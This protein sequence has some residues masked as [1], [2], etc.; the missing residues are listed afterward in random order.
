MGVRKKLGWGV[1]KGDKLGEGKRRIEEK[2]K[3][4][5]SSEKKKKTVKPLCHL[6]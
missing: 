6:D 2:N 4:N 1:S 3:S 5:K